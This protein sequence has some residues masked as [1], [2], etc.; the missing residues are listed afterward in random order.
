MLLLSTAATGSQAAPSCAGRAC[1][2]TLD[3]PWAG[4]G[5]IYQ[6]KQEFVAALRQLSIAL[7]GRFGDEGRSV[8][9]D[10]DS[11]ENALRRWDQAIVAFE[12][13]LQQRGYDTEAHTALGTVY[14]DRYRVEDALRSFEAAVKLDARRADV[15]RFMAMAHG[16]ANRPSEAVRALTRAAA[17]QPDDAVVR[18]EIARYAMETS[19]SP[20]SSAIFTSFQDAADKQLAQ[21]GTEP[22]F[23]RPGLLRQAAGVAPIFPPAPYVETFELLMKGKFEEA[24]AECR[25]AIDGEPLLELSRRRRPARHRQ[26]RA[27]TGRSIWSAQGVAGSRAGQPVTNRGA[28]NPRRRVTAGRADRTERRGLHRSDSRAPD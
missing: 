1:G 14:L 26:R 24:I 22:P 18:Y 9:S 28:S 25:R 23:T 10:I 17:L 4:A 20:P 11:L 8:R 2:P 12:M 16:L 15:Y 3:Q 7:T 6:R 13:A 5:E 27:E 19:T 21:N